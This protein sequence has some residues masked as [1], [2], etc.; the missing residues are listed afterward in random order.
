MLDIITFDAKG[1]GNI[2]YKALAHPVASEALRELEAVLAQDTPLAVYDPL[3]GLQTLCALYPG[4]RP[5]GGVYTHDS[6][7]VG[8]A[9]GL[10]GSKRALVDMAQDGPRVILVLSF[11]HEKMRQRLGRLLNHDH[12]VFSLEPAKIP[13]SLLSNKRSYLDNRTSRRTSLFF[14]TTL[15]SAHVSSRLTTGVIMAPLRSFTGCVSIVI[16]ERSLLSGRSPW[17]MPP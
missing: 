17:P 14:V 1:G 10:G 3:N 11:E 12:K 15:C 9:D 4:L 8:Q 7:Q 5:S 2:L 6:E 16:R 13:Q